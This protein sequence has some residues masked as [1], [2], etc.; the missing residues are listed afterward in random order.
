MPPTRYA[1][2][3]GAKIAF[4]VSGEG[5]CDLV[6]VPG[7]VSHLDLQWQQLNYRRF[8]TALERA[9]RVIRFDKRGTGLSDP[10]DT[11]PGMDERV[12]DL[13]AV[14]DAAPSRAAVVFGVSDGGRGAIAFAAAH[15]ERV[16]GLVLY[17]TSHRGPRDALLRRYRSII[18]RW[19]EGDLIA[20]VAPS[21][22][23]P[24]GRDAAGAFERAAAS[25]GM[26]EALIESMVRADVSPLLPAV[27]APTLVV[28]RDHDMIPLADARVVAS[29]IP[30]AVLKV[31]PGA[32]HLPW[33]GEWE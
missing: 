31:V 6:L 7:L 16:A 9:C 25:P 18:G 15:P 22:A 21:L 1:Q 30:G 32:D 26:A 29:A 28:H 24:A 13:A 10:T 17:G 12:M 3:A 8:M 27:Q 19:G 14:M 2:S 20:L 33:A 11:L 5:S 23:G 4:Q